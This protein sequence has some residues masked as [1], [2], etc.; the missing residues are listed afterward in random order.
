MIGTWRRNRPSP[1]LALAASCQLDL[2]ATDEL[3]G[4]LAEHAPGRIIATPILTISGPALVAAKAHLHAARLV[5]FSS[6]NVAIDPDADIYR[7]LAVAETNLSLALPQS[8]LLRPTMIYGYPGDGNLSRLLALLRKLP[9]VP[10]P[11]QGLALQ[12]PIHVEDLARAAAHAL[13]ITGPEKTFALGGPDKISLRDLL[14]TAAQA[15][16]KP[17]RTLTIPREALNAAAALRK[18]GLPLPVTAAQLN[19]LEKDKT[20]EGPTLPGWSP[21]INLRQ[22]L[23]ALALELGFRDGH[24]A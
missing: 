23:N 18:T 3:I 6:N 21:T 4:L 1:D 2:G 12:Q 19:R 5:A 11:G 17:A 16:G 22:G 10:V 24:N 15:L 20:T 8:V 13:D 9:L 7:R 14:T